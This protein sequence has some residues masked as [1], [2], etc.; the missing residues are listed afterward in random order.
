M[1]DD[2]YRKWLLNQPASSLGQ[3]AP[4]WISKMTEKEV[5]DKITEWHNQRVSLHAIHEHLGWTR[6]E[7]VIWVEE[8][9]IP[10]TTSQPSKEWIQKMA[11][12]EDQ[13]E[14]VLAGSPYFEKT[15]ELDDLRLVMRKMNIWPCGEHQADKVLFRAIAGN[16][17]F[18]D[19]VTQIRATIEHDY[20]LHMIKGIALDYLKSKFDGKAYVNNDGDYVL[21]Q[22]TDK[23][24][25]GCPTLIFALE[26]ASKA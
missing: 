8:K 10:I 26:V 24:Q 12:K 16:W 17:V 15:T 9:I 1:T 23:Y 7:Y 19:H 2:E 18:R 5:N 13:C 11:E 25:G 20:A 3:P 21:G 14:S 6:E 22:G 4:E